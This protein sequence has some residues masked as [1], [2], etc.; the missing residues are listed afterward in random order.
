MST[1][2]VVALWCPD[3]PVV[4]AGLD[5]PAAA[6]AVVADGRV[7]ACSAA[8]RADGVR[9]GQRQREA[10]RHC[11]DLLVRQDAPDVEARAFERV[12]AAAE[13]LCPRL[14]VVRP[15]ICAAPAR[16][17]A[18]YFGGERAFAVR[19]RDA[20]SSVRPVEG[21]DRP[22]D[23]RVGVADGLFAAVLAARATDPAAP[24]LVVQPADTATFLGGHHVNVLDRPELTALLV[25]LGIRTLGE[26]AVLP[27]DDVQAR[28]GA[29]GTVAHRLARGRGPRPLAPRSPARDLAVERTFDPPLEQFEQVV[30]VAKALAHEL[31][32]A[33]AELGAVCVRV[34]V[35]VTTEDGRGWSRLWRHDGLLSAT[36]VA[37]RVRWQLDAWR[38]TSPAAGEAL[39]GGLVSLRLGPDQLVHDRD[40]QLSLW[41]EFGTD[42]RVDRAATR[43]ATMLG[44]GGVT[45]PLLGG[46]RGPGEQ[47]TRVPWGDAVASRLPAEGSW[48]G[49]LPAPAPAVVFRQP[50][51]ARLVDAAG[52][53]VA[54]TGRG[55]VSAA[56]DLLAVRPDGG[57]P[58]RVTG[59]TGPWP[60]EEFWWDPARRVR[61]A[62]FQVTTEDDRAWL[63]LLRDERWW[64]E[65]RY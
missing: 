47:V 38:A 14:E 4:T 29:D 28:F 5:D 56:P 3:W 33:L 65:A 44:H 19:L 17:P 37:E 11:P 16:G 52:E 23:C 45:R 22:L 26:F 62:R 42:E 64:A 43:I 58:V 48:P 54:V 34:R 21:T 31:H 13:Q 50:L 40:R 59:W 20:V 6:V 15:G 27:D 18:R 7:V 24:Y 63:L 2:R 51:P 46:G 55:A 10:Q 12:A 35:E 39:T 41:G 36:A 61:F 49:R 60:A 8:A 30:F 53:P 9:R 1:G 32:A 57:G 25:R